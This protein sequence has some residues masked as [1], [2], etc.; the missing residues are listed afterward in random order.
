MCEDVYVYHN[1]LTLVLVFK[2]FYVVDTITTKPQTQGHAKLESI[3]VNGFSVSHPVLTMHP[4]RFS[5]SFLESVLP[6]SLYHEVKSGSISSL[7][8]FPWPTVRLD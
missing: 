8:I 5:E 4:V 1:S 3:D 7:A 2:S 6:V